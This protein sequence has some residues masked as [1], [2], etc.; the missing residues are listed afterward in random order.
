MRWG[1]G[2]CTRV[3]RAVAG[4]ALTVRPHGKGVPFSSELFLMANRSFG[5][6]GMGGGRADEPIDR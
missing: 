1:R 5:R 6:G 3:F 4:T 2:G